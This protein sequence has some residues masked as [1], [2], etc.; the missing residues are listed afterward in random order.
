MHA[1][2]FAAVLV[3]CALPLSA[4][5]GVLDDLE[6]LQGKTI[7]YAGDIQ[8]VSCPIGGKFDCF[9]WPR[10]FYKTT[11]GACFVT[12]ETSCSYGCKALIA[13]DQSR[14]VSVFIPQTIGAGM[15][16]GSFTPYKC[17]SLY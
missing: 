11:A 12:D 1:P 4:T 10:G 7:I 15:K 17:P 14:Q 9:Q 8:Q 3:V 6:E 2:V 16:K 5:A 13:T